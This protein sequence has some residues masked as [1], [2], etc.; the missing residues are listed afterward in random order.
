ML[1]NS[2]DIILKVKYSMDISLNTT[3]ANTFFTKWLQSPQEDS[4]EQH[5]R[6]RE[7]HHCCCRT[8]SFSDVKP[9]LGMGVVVSWPWG[10]VGTS[11]VLVVS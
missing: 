6:T 9:E 4:R 1:I 2:N 8:I 7:Q 10:F 11:D 5:H 3:R